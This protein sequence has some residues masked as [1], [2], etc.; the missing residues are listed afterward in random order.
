M[1]DKR[2]LVFLQNAWS[3]YYAGSTWPRESWLRALEA[4]KSGKKLKLMIDDLSVVYN[5]TPEVGDK[6]SSKL[7]PDLNHMAKVIHIQDPEVIVACGKQAEEAVYQV[8][9]G[10]KIVVPHPACRWLRD[11]FYRSARALIEVALIANECQVRLWQA[12]GEPLKL[13]GRIS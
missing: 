9:T 13:T 12:K 2:I 1:S 11:D 6:A 10:K 5:T 7:P 8:W 3:E 4:R